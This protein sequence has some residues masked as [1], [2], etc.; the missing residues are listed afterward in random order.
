M[1][2]SVGGPRK[3]AISEINVT[4][5]ADVMIVLLIIF[6]IAMPYVLGA[7]VQLPVAK[8]VAEQGDEQLEIVVSANGLITAGD[9]AFASVESLA[10]FLSIKTAATATPR[11]LIQADRRV[12][13]ADVARVLTA[14]R[15][16]G[17]REVALAARKRLGS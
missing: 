3:G 1:S 17:A 16:S 11:V 4:P 13:Y 15:R 9:D 8:H 2:M 12:A 7:P 10:D 5:M 14:C 6:M